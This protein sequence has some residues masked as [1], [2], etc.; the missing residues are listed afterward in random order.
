MCVLESVWGRKH[1]LDRRWLCERDVGVI[2]PHLLQ[3]HAKTQTYFCGLGLGL[4]LF[5]KNP[6]IS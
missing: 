4:L 5:V 3:V 6:L 2:K 1:K